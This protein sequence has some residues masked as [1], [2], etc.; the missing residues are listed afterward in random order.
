MIVLRLNLYNRYEHRDIQTALICIYN[1]K[2]KIYRIKY[3]IK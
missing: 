2:K 3:I 1:Y